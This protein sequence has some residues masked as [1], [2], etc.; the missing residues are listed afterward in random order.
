MEAV[1]EA[2][3]APRHNAGRVSQPCMTVETLDGPIIRRAHSATSVISTIRDH[4]ESDTA[5][6][7]RYY[8]DSR[9]GQTASFIMIINPPDLII[10]DVTIF[11][12]ASLLTRRI[13]SQIFGQS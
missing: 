10:T 13:F 2:L 4:L 11:P 8:E 5:F 9:H 3:L 6:A 12:G 7:F 1:V